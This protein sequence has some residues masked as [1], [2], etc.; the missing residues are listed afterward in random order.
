[1]VSE[2]IM[3]KCVGKKIKITLLDDST[4]ETFCEQFIRKEDDEDEAMLFLPNSLA[5]LQSEIKSIKI[6]E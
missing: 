2:K 1:M 4:V 5:A 6:L 3:A